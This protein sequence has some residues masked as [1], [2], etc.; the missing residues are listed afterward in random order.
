VK[1]LVD[2]CIWSLALRR[3]S[4]PI[5]PAVIELQELIRE[6]RV[7]MIGPVRQEILSGIRSREHYCKVRDHISPFVD[8]EISISDYERAA[9]FFNIARSKGIQ[10]SNTDFLICAIAERYGLSIFT[11]DGDFDLFARHFSVKLYTPR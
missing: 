2:T 9:E 4:L 3:K 11:H 8:L 5:D 1:V 7:Q 10:G 6:F